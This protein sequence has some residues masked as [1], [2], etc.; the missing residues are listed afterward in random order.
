[1]ART[2]KLQLLV[3]AALAALGVT[4]SLSLQATPGPVRE[5][6]LEARGMAFYREGGEV[7]NPILEAVAGERLRFVLTNRDRGFEHDLRLPG[8]GK[9]SGQL[10]EG[11]RATITVRVPETAGDVR[12]DCSLHAAMMTGVIRVR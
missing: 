4:V 9:A 6:R 7:Q 1:M 11:A 3:V 10:A 2:R 12:Y 8:L 5:V